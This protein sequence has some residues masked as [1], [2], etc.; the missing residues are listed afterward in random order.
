MLENMTVVDKVSGDRE[1]D[2]DRRGMR[3]ADAVAPIVDGVAGAVGVL[4]RHVVEEHAFG[5]DLARQRRP[6]E[7]RSRQSTE[8][9]LMN[10]EVVILAGEIDELPALLGR[11]IA[12][13]ERQTNVGVIGSNGVTSMNVPGT[14]TPF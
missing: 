4:Q 11:R 13:A 14:G 8:F 6:G 1:R 7:F 12:G 3:H 9:G 5:E 2:L 10:V